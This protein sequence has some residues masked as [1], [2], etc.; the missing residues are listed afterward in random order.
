[1]R[2]ITLLSLLLG[3]Q[4]WGQSTFIRRYELPPSTIITGVTATIN[5][6]LAICGTRNVAGH[7]GSLVMSLDAG[8]SVQWSRSVSA[9]GSDYGFVDT[10]E[11]VLHDLVALSNGD[12]VV[13]GSTE[14]PDPPFT[15]IG[16]KVLI[17]FSGS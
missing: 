8:G 17:R 12:L 3:A 7:Q 10:C 1:M 2:V 4:A 14:E 11:V 9:Y 15:T 13:A 5:D 16:G 6:G